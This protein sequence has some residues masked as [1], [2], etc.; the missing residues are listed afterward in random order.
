ML[1]LSIFGFRA[2]WSP[3]FLIVLVIILSTYYFITVKYRQRFS[4]SEPLTRKQATY[5]TMGMMLLYV[6]KGSPIDLLGHITFYM[7]MIQM[8]VLYL[9]VAPFIILGIPQ[10]IWRIIIHAR[11]IKT[12]FRFFTKPLISLVLFNGL[13]SLYHLPLIFDFIKTNFFYHAGYTAFL[14]VMAIFMWW[15]LL[16]PLPEEKKLLG[17]KKIGYIFADGALLTPACA[18][19]IFADA[20]VYATFSDPRAW[21]QSLELCVPVATLSGLKL[22]GPEMFSS[23]SLLHDQQLG[24][25]LMKVI[26]EIVYGTMLYRVFFQWYREEQKETELELIV[27]E[28]NHPIQVHPQPVSK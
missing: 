5:F 18:L 12:L 26:Q 4:T 13:F 19:I 25:V 23:M 3:Y 1:P 7:H 14:F 28:V 10:W 21:A 11:G 8:A 6:V 27:S 2:L 9:I 20:P 15:P 22:S 24:G 17:L 16:N